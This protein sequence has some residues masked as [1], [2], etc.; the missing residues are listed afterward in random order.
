MLMS[1]EALQYILVV[2][3]L[4]TYVNL[5]I[6][7][8]FVISPPNYCITQ[9]VVGFKDKMIMYHIL[10]DRLK[11]YREMACK[12]C[13][14]VM[15]S[16]LGQ[17]F[18]A[19]LGNGISIYATYQGGNSSSFLLLHSFTGHVGPVKSL[20]W[21]NDNILFSAGI[22]KNIYGW[23]MQHGT[24]VDSLNVLRS[25]GNCNA[26]VAFSSNKRL[27]VAACTS[28]GGVYRIDCLGTEKCEV[29]TLIRQ[30]EDVPVSICLNEERSILYVGTTR[31]VIR[32]I[33]WNINTSEMTC[34]QEI[35]LHNRHSLSSSNS[36][37]PAIRSIR[38]AR[39]CL[40]TAGGIDGSIFL[41]LTGQNSNNKSLVSSS[42]F[43]NDNI[44]LI[45]LE[46][47]KQSKD[48]VVELEQ[49]IITLN[50]D[51]EFALHSKDALWRN[52]IKELT[53]KTDEIVEA[54]Q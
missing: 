10:I 9:I 5:Y 22:D 24:R 36:I 7:E 6:F 48:L 13:H 52:E 39:N 53:D 54:E 2:I 11:S 47:Y 51:H 19:V 46:D 33:N 29:K 44:V 15:F 34:F 42:S 45:T 43:Q 37:N 17:Y 31:G 32:C 18:A 49:Q 41:S 26:L 20:S 3:R 14:K 21:A 25:F 50:N 40:I 23:D 8:R 16:P 1:L 12:I 28:D 38:V 35:Y 4:E 27:E 30:S